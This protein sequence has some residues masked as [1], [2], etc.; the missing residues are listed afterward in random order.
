MPK[1][2][3]LVYIEWIDSDGSD[4]SEWKFIH[5]FDK[6]GLQICQSVGW[7]LHDEKDYKTILHNIAGFLNGDKTKQGCGELTIPVSAI[8]KIKEIKL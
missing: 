4:K 1:P 3:K 7:M 6:S 2:M 5:E 8:R